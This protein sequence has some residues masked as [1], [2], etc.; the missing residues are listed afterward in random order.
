MELY[1]A[2]PAA[3]RHNFFLSAGNNYPNPDPK[4]ASLDTVLK[5]TTV[6]DFKSFRSGTLVLSC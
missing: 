1:T 5:T 4:P 6:P 2:I 3:F